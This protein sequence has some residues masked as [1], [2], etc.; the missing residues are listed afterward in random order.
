MVTGG[1]RHASQPSRLG[2][3]QEKNGGVGLLDEG[4]SNQERSSSEKAKM[5]FVLRDAGELFRNCNWSQV[6]PGKSMTA[7]ATHEHQHAYLAGWLPVI[8]LIIP[9]PSP[10]CGLWGGTTA[11]RA[12]RLVRA[13]QPLTGPAAPENGSR[14]P[15]SQAWV[16]GQEAP[17]VRT[18]LALHCSFP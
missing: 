18:T 14:C 6:Q 7:T 8:S 2:H 1:S 10:T 9:E 4:R 17:P 15:P 13:Q 5:H 12:C 3:E 16:P 11:T